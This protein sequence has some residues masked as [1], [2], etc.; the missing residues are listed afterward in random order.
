ME[1][2]FSILEAAR[3]H[4]EKDFVTSP[5]LRVPRQESVSLKGWALPAMG[6]HSAQNC[7]SNEVVGLRVDMAKLTEVVD[8][9]VD[10]MLTINTVVTRSGHTHLNHGFTSLSRAIM[11]TIFR[12]YWLF[13]KRSVSTIFPK[14]H[15]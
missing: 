2:D 12:R 11:S 8:T 9:L 5:K 1:Q 13:A 15:A 7:Q 10:T 6:L 3:S 4:S 14:A